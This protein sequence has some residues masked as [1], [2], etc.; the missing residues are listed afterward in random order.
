MGIIGYTKG[1]LYRDNGES[2]GNQTD[3][4]METTITIAPL[5]IMIITA[6][7]AS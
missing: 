1:F 5:I 7:S 3:N 2:N 6:I 4:E